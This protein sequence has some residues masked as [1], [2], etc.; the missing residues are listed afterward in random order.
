MVGMLDFVVAMG[1]ALG[2]VDNVMVTRDAEMGVMNPKRHV[3]P[4]VRR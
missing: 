4:T 1:N 2:L 3:G